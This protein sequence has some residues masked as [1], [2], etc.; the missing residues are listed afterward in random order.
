VEVGLVTGLAVLLAVTVEALV[1]EAV[2]GT[3]VEAL[4][5]TGVTL[6]GVTVDALVGGGDG[7]LEPLVGGGT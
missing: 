6:E 2:V 1:V 3:A 5:A 4:V 7:V